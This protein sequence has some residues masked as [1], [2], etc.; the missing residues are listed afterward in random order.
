MR[1]SIM[2]IYNIIDLRI[3]E[4]IYILKLKPVLNN[5]ISA[6]PLHILNK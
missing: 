2:Y 6:F 1:K 4:Y 5:S 3:L